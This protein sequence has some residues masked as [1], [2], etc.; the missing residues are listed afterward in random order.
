MEMH[1]LRCGVIY[2]GDFARYL[3]SK[4]LEEGRSRDG[5]MLS[6]D[7]VRCRSG[8]QA[9]QAWWQVSWIHALKAS[10]ADCFRIGTTDVFIHRQSQRGLRHRLL[11]WAAGGIVVKQ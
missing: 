2:S 5:E 7:Y 1:R 6:I 4:V 9:G 3:S 11:H 8:P 10:A